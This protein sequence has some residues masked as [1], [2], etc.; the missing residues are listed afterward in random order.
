[1]FLCQ[2]LLTQSPQCSRCWH[3]PMNKTDKIPALKE[4]LILIFIKH[5]HTNPSFFTVSQCIME[6]NQGNHVRVW[7]FIWCYFGI[8]TSWIAINLFRSVLRYVD[9]L[10][11]LNMVTTFLNHLQIID[12]IKVFV[13]STVRKK[14]RKAVS[15]TESPG[16][17]TGFRANGNV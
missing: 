17:W 16:T 12:L 11:A 15:I 6:C 4:I 3:T 2:Q 13:L 7:N 14:N 10:D 5:K 1:M 8:L 9:K